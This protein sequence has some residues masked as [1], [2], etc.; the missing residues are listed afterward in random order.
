MSR[1]RP[2]ESVAVL[3]AAVTALAGCTPSPTTTVVRDDG[4]QVTLDWADYPGHAWVD[5]EQALAAP[6]Q[7]AAERIGANLLDDVETAL[8]ARV[9]LTWST[10]TDASWAPVGGN[11]YGGSSAYITYNSPIRE[12]DDLPTDPQDWRA[13]VDV[14]SAVAEEHGLG[15]VVLEH[16]RLRQDGEAEA[17]ASLHEEAGTADPDRFWSWSG[18]ADSG[19]QWLSVTLTDVRRHPDAAKIDEYRDLGLPLRSISLDYGVT[20]VADD[21][22][23]G[24]RARLAPF[25]S[26]DKPEATGSD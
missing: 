19:T 2:T 17:L 5:A 4:E 13:L 15:P 9:D 26:L 22:R 14:V 11:G 16:E 10:R 21:E 6:S 25:E 7:A 20:T 3:V 24:F 1:R 8:D 18:T 12:T 23:A